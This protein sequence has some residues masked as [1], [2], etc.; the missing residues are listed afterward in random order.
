MRVCDLVSDFIYNAGV[1]D[2]F[3]VS[4]GG[5]MFLTDGLACN[6]NLNVVSCHHEQAAAMAAVGYAKYRG[7]GCAYV[8]TG[9]GGT[10]AIT[11]LLNAWQDNIACIF[12][13][14][15]C[16][17]KETIRNLGIPIR[18]IGVQ[19][20]DI[21]SIVSSIT[22]Y[23]VMVDDSGDILYHLQKALWIA[24]S[25]RPGPVWIDIPM[26]VQSANIDIDKLRTFDPSEMSDIKLEATPSELSELERL[27]I[28]AKRPVII[29]GGGVRMSGSI[30]EFGKLVHSHKI[31][32]VTSRM[33]LDVQPTCDNLY[34][35]RIGNKG[36][37]AANI[38]LQ[39]ADLIVALGSRLSVSSTGQEYKYFARGATVVA[40]D[41]DPY[42]HTKG[43]V[44][45]EKVINADLKRLLKALKLP[46]GLSYNA[47]AQYCAGL[48]SK[49]P[50]CPEDCR[51]DS[52]GISMYAF[53]DELSKHFKPDS[54]LVTDAGSAVYVPAQAIATSSPF[55]RYITSGAQA[56]MGYSLPA[57]IGVCVARNSAE[58]LAITGDGSLQMN[59][60]EFQT[61]VHYKLP[62]KLFVWNNDGY[63]S[64]RATQRKF[65]K[66][67]FI[68]TDSTSGVS[69]PN[70]EKL[71]GA[72]GL[73]YVRI[74]S[75]SS[76]DSKLAEVMDAECPVICEVMCIRDEVVRPVV[77]SKQLPDGKMV[78]MPIEDM[79]PFL[80][81]DEFVKNMIVPPAEVSLK[82]E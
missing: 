78:S 58:T 69:F 37:R 72:Y 32:F 76:I 49:Y 4:G 79:Y 63:L 70:L 8:T 42:E 21:V 66:G 51:N 73:K 22:K 64:I 75:L 43:T 45:I 80:P 82:S 10:N 77:S 71:S 23:S 17:R 24:K 5:L 48:K 65:F 62:V 15:Q 34:I 3:M 41:I 14:G 46:E 27:F 40:V 18:Q 6:R 31:P 25:G 39:N 52:H 60:Q 47:W 9:C 67:R 53:V 28:E 2:V 55:Q 56:E 1:E 19:E 12:I 38:A 74:D 54:V 59:I 33:G 29:A 61:L 81:R 57:A 30:E 36:N 44:H 20:A 50:N 7:L 13:S 11:G 16:K 35:G 68:G 26:D